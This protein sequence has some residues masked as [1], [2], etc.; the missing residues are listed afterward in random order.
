MKEDMQVLIYREGPNTVAFLSD[1]EGCP[2]TPEKRRCP[3]VKLPKLGMCNHP[4]HWEG[5]WQLCGY[6]GG[7]HTGQKCC[8]PGQAVVK[9]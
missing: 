1:P 5:Q 9:Y 3:A 4:I 2:K 8:L 7:T 6:C